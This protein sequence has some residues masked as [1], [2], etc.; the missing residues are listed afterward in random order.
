MRHG[1]GYTQGLSYSGARVVR[2][3]E[4]LLNINNLKVANFV[5]ATLANLL[6][7]QYLQQFW[8]RNFKAA[9]GEHFHL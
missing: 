6:K 3:E 8:R 1:H 2:Q 7:T 5:R 4:Y 9:P